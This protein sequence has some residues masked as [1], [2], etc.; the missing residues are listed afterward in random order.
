MFVEPEL[1]DRIQQLC[2]KITATDND[3]ELLHLCQELRDAL[4]VHI[5]H[6][7]EQVSDFR[8]SS[9]TKRKKEI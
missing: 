4:Q 7:R 9:K 8:R 2:S 3:E 5:R 6:L 1:E